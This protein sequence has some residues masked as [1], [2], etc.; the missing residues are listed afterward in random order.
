MEGMFPEHSL[1]K[2]KKPFTE[3]TPFLLRKIRAIVIGGKLLAT[4]SL[5]SISL[6]SR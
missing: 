1:K 6:I 4:P 2:K 5:A 3:R